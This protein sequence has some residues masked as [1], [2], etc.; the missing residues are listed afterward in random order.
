MRT[1]R[2]V[3]GS[4][5]AV[6]SS[7]SSSSSS[8]SVTSKSPDSLL[9]VGFELEAD[10]HKPKARIESQNRYPL[11]ANSTATFRCIVHGNP[12]PKL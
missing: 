12:E 7:S 10:I 11:T 1:F 5:A 2:F 8:S 6:L 4:I 9:M 3:V